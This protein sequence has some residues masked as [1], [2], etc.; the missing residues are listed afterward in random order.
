MMW[1]G[2]SVTEEAV[3]FTYIYTFKNVRLK[4]YQTYSSQTFTIFLAKRRCEKWL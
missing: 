4:Y 1:Y 2:Y 3:V